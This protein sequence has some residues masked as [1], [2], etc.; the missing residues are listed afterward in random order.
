MDT[1]FEITIILDGKWVKIEMLVLPKSFISINQEEGESGAVVSA[2]CWSLS[3]SERRLCT[4]SW[5]HTHHSVCYHKK[6]LKSKV[7]H[8][9]SYKV[10][11]AEIHSYGFDSLV[12]EVLVRSDNHPSPSDK[13]SHYTQVIAE[14]HSQRLWD[15]SWHHSLH[16]IV[17]P[18]TRKGCNQY[19]LV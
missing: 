13:D 17:C 14:D 19:L 11:R 8:I 12:G 10:C 2:D 9:S 5:P 16:T 7:I 6:G 3:V 18:Q 1:N 4:I 15:R